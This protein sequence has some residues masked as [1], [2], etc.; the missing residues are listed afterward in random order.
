MDRWMSRVVTLVIVVIALV[1]L[2]VLGSALLGYVLHGVKDNE[3]A[4][5]LRRSVI[6]SVVG[7]GVYTD[8]NPFA[9]IV[10]VKI[11]GVP[12]CAED[13]EVL[14]KDQQRIGVKVCGTAHRPGLEKSDVLQANWS[15]YRTFYTSDEALVGRTRTE[16]GQLI[17]E[18]FGLMQNIAQQA[19]KV[20]VGDRTFAQ[21]VVGTARDEMRQCVDEQMSILAIN[22]GGIEVKNIVVPN[23]ILGPEVQ[24]L[25]DQ[26]TKS[27]FEVDL[28]RQDTLKAEENGRRQLAEQQA[29]IRVEQ[30]RVQEL[31]R[32]AAITADLERQALEAQMAVINA[33]KANDLLIAQR[34]L[35]IALA[36][37]EVEKAKA[38]AL[39]AKDTALAQLYSEHPEFL[40]YLVQLGWAN[41]L[42]QAGAIYIPSGTD[43]MTIIQPNGQGAQVVIPAT[44]TP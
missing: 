23:I 18:S 29:T 44:P 25:L 34:D 38:L 30:G 15:Q 1:I 9:D 41:A 13:A 14:T 31:Q 37:L 3:I 26:I 39:I 28:A 4:V 8:W 22:Y 21:A 27:K 10:E 32:Q 17:T 7:P 24:S 11:E 40:D 20:C 42:A 2:A 16:N 19:M 35:E 36:K 6:I 12:F 43:P 33:E 5:K